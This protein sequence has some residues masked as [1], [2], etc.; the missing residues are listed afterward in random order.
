ME[1]EKITAAGHKAGCYVGWDLAHAGKNKNEREEREMQTH[2]SNMIFTTLI[3]FF[4]SLFSAVGNIPLSLHAWQVDFAAWCSYKYLNAGPGSIGGIFVH[5]R[6]HHDQEEGEKEEEEGKRGERKKQLCGWW[7]QDASVRFQMR[8]THTPKP[9]AQSYMLS[10]PAVL[11]TV[12]LQA[13]LEVFREANMKKLRAKSMLLTGWLE[14]LIHKFLP[15]TD[16]ASPSSP[17]TCTILTPTN[18]TH[19]GAQL[20]LLFSS[21]VQHINHLLTEKGIVTDV[22]RPN[23]LRISPAPLYNN[24]M[25]VWKVVKELKEIMEK[26]GEE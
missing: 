21:P 15:L 8:P 12:C 6:H 20:S 13:S 9:G 26:Y 17:L 10:N 5:Q 1:I 11:P 3:I 2:H 16:K 19:R 18:P 24:F 4:C 23:V 14:L 22:R 25:D 7:G